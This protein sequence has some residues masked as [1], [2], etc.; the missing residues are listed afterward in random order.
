MIPAL[1]RDLGRWSPWARFKRARDDLDAFIY[2]EIA[3][4]RSEPGSASATTFSR[5]CSPRSTTTA[6]R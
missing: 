1:R 3:N 5:C 2:E 4:R 6:R